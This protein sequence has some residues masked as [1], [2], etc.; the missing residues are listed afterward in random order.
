MGYFETFYVQRID[1]NGIQA[2]RTKILDSE[3]VES[4]EF[5]DD[6]HTKVYM[7]SGD[8]YILHIDFGKFTDIISSNEDHLGRLLTF[9][10]N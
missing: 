6:S 5:I 10:P 4:W 9:N 2:Y 3:E 7:R 1:R 8:K